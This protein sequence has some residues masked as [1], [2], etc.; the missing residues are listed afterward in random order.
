MGGQRHAPDAF[1]PGKDPVPIVQQAG[2]APG[3]VWIAAENLAHT[4]IRSPDLPARSESLYGLRYPGP[5]GRSTV[6]KIYASVILPTGNTRW[7]DLER[8]S[9]FRGDRQPARQTTIVPCNSLSTVSIA[10]TTVLLSFA[11]IFRIKPFQPED[12]S[13]LGR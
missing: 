13:I 6:T 4:G 1:T 5:E 12:A 10:R 8:N 11:P 2:S 3:P 7:S 9:G